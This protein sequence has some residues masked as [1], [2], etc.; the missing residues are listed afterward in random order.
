[1]K[2]NYQYGEASPASSLEAGTNQKNG[3]MG[4]AMKIQAMLASQRV[5]DLALRAVSTTLILSLRKSVVK[6]VT[7]LKLAPATAVRVNL[8]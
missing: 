2:G 1:M 7:M 4:V 5:L 8:V 6:I 3:H